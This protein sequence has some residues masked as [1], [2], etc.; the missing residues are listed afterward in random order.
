[1]S[2]T[3]NTS[4]IV[5]IFNIQGELLKILQF[6]EGQAVWNYPKGL[7]GLVILNLKIGSDSYSTK[8]ILQK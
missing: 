3:N 8:V 2:Y 4:G 6:I 5:K 7:S 1:M